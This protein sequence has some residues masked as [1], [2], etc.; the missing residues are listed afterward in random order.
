MAKILLGFIPGL[1][2][3]AIFLYRDRKKPE[4]GYMIAKIFLFGMLIT[5]AAVIIE[6]AFVKIITGAFYIFLIIAPTEEILKYLVFKFKVAKAKAYDEPIDAMIYMITIALG[7]A[8]VENIILILK[9]GSQ[10]FNLLTLRFLSATLL[11]ALASGIVGYY[12]GAKKS[13]SAGL[14]WAIAFH[15]VYNYIALLHETLALPLLAPLLILM[16]IIVSR[17]F[18]KIKKI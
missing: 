2:W 16:F 12:L 17:E 14:F 4:P 3:L 6:M 15:G 10:T 5:P 7:F 1:I 8:T 9:D 13:V 11:H 18:K